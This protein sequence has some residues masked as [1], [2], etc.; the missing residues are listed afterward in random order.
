MTVMDWFV[1]QIKEYSGVDA[2]PFVVMKKANLNNI[3]KNLM[4]SYCGVIYL[5]N[6]NDFS[7][8][9]KCLFIRHQVVCEVA[10]RGLTDAKSTAE[11]LSHFMGSGV[12]R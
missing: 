1:F 10:K 3:F 2:Y 5:D 12:R 9:E 6:R 8:P 11:V 7:I 4:N